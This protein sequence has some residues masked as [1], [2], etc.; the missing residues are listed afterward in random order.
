MTKKTSENINN[1]LLPKSP[2]LTSINKNFENIKQV[3]NVSN[4]IIEE[5]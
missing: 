2:Y 1:I 3:L 4:L 5:K